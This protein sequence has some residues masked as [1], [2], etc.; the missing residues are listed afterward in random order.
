MPLNTQKKGGRESRPSL[1]FVARPSYIFLLDH[2]TFFCTT[3]LHFFARPSCILHFLFNFCSTIL[4]FLRT[5]YILIDASS[6]EYIA[7]YILIDP[8]DKFRRTAGRKSS[9]GISMGVAAGEAEAIKTRGDWNAN[10]SSGMMV[11]LQDHRAYC[12]S[13]AAALML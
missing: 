10:I 2:L 8:P 11:S 9:H 3:I 12:V 1:H 7:L 6:K 4:I 5:P 13:T